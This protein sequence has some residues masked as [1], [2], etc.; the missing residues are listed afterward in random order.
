[1]QRAMEKSTS[2][3]AAAAWRESRRAKRR[4]DRSD[5]ERCSYMPEA[6]PCVVI[7]HPDRLHVGVADGRADELE[8]ALEQVLAQRIGLGGLDRDLAAPEHDRLAADEAPEVGVEAAELLLHGEKGFRVADG[9]L[10]F[11]PIADDPRILQQYPFPARIETRDLSRI[12]SRERLPVV[13]ALLQ[14]RFP[15]EPGLR[16]F[17]DQELEQDAIVVHRHAP[18]LVVVGDAERRARPSAAPTL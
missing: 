18:F 6:V 5:S 16:A 8:A 3:S 14:D 17:E 15:R 12:E 10:D 9:A 2:A 7:R 11:Q 1:M 13:L 4:A